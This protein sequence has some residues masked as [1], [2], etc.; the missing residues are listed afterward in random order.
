MGF[1]PIFQGYIKRS[2]FY[3]HTT[4]SLFVGIAQCMMW[5]VAPLFYIQL[6]RMF[7]LAQWHLLQ[8]DFR[9][10][11]MYESVIDDATSAV[12]LALIT[13]KLIESF[14]KGNLLST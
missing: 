11:S 10:K 1:L 5:V 7:A 6:P 2:K 14:Y 3:I 13:I 12:S 9:K 8:R 4:V